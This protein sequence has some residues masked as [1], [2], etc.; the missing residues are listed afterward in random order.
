MQG[1]NEEDS[2]FDEAK[3][4]IDRNLTSLHH[5]LVSSLMM[6]GIP[7]YLVGYISLLARW[8]HRLSLQPGE[9][10]ALSRMQCE[11]SLAYVRHSAMSLV[12]S[13]NIH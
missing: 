2:T 7:Y 10:D 9:K 1:R 13:V 8:Q 11:H 3:M 6:S 12:C 4:N 5:E